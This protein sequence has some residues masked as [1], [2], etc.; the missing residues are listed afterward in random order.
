MAVRRALIQEADCIGCGKCTPVCPTDAIVGAP[1]FLH[2]VLE[3]DCIGCERCVPVCPVDC[4]SLVPMQDQFNP[5]KLTQDARKARSSYVRTLIS[6][7][8]IRLERERSEEE[9]EFRLIKKALHE[10]V[11]D[12]RFARR[13]FLE[14]LL[15]P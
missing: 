12:Q 10:E 2:N 13:A 9:R 8:K 5:A 7:R 6:A 4:I 1:K 11:K 15:N 3:A 14:K